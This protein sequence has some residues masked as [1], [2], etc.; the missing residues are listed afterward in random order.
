MKSQVGLWIDHR[1]AK[2]V[3]LSADT[4]NTQRS[5]LTDAVASGIEKHV[6]FAGASAEDGSADDQRDRQ[7]A[8]HLNKYY[9]EVIKHLDGADSIFICGPGEAKGEL[10]KRL[11]SKGLGERISGVQ[12]VDKLTD[13]QLEALLRQHFLAPKH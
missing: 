5:G 6:R 2:I 7:F 9:D 1:E 11:I 8:S 10:K 12:T 4:G 3:M 13:R